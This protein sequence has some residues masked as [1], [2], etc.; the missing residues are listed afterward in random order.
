MK[1]C[2]ACHKVGDQGHNVGPN[3]ATTKNKSDND[4]LIAILDPSR[5]AQSNYNTYTIVTDQGKLF[6]GIIAAETATSYTIRSAEGKEDIILGTTLIRCC[7]MV[8]L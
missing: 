8:S 1:N 2:A 7:P 5:E 4:L 3:L 6:T